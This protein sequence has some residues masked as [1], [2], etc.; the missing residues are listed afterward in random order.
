M[1]NRVVITGVGVVSS[2]GDSSSSLHPLYAQ[3]VAHSNR[4]SYSA[5]QVSAVLWAAKSLHSMH[6]NIWAGEIC[7]HWI[8][9][10]ASLL[11]QR[12]WP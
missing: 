11:P 12:N 4:L 2:L 3:A 7:A 5:R 1:R 8:E 10:H 6:R 9:H